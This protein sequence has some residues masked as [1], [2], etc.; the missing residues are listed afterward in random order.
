MRINRKF[1]EGLIMEKYNTRQRKILLDYLTEHVDETLSA[2]QIADG[3]KNDGISLSAVYRNLSSLE[4]EGLVK[5]TSKTGS[6]EVFFQY[7]AAP[8]CRECL[9]MSCKKCGKIFHMHSKEAEQLVKLAQKDGFT[10]DK[11]ETV[12]YGICGLCR[13]K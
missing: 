7:T 10:V 13:E 8:E 5:R 1:H 12:L 6:R 4:D 3:L 11:S 2:K 9:H